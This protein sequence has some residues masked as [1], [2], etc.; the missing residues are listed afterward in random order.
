MFAVTVEFVVKMEWV[1]AFISRVSQQARDSLTHE[2]NC[3]IFDVCRD[4]KI[5][6]RIFLYEIYTDEDAFKLHLAS[7]HYLSFDQ[8]TKSW[9]ESKVP[10]FFNRL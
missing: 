5:P 8:E 4:T 3:H 1:D 6:N 2:D 7:E 9:I 10:E